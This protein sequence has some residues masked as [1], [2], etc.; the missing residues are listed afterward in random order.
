MAFA[1]V[2]MMSFMTKRTRFLIFF[3]FIALKQTDIRPASKADDN[4]IPKVPEN[5]ILLKMDTTMGAIY[6]DLDPLK[7]KKLV[8]HFLYNVD[9]GFYKNIIFH[10]VIEGFIIQTGKFDEN[11]EEKQTFNKTIEN[12]LLK[13]PLKN[14]YGTVA[15][16]RE[17]TNSHS[18]TTEFYINLLDNPKLDIK[19]K[20]YGYS[21]F[22]TIIQGMEIAKKISGIKTWERDG[23]LYAPF[24]P[25]EA[26]I[27]DIYRVPININKK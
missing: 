20:A 2:N 17:L 3:L 5:H 6:I 13:N 24:F 19:N 12:Q 18:E 25:N 8:K 14:S 22:G 7:E 9:H 1:G 4:K 15:M 16:T 21:V 27:K 10:R 23:L 26:L 11:F